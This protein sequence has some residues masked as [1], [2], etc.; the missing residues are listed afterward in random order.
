[1]LA[2]V[3]NDIRVGVCGDPQSA[4]NDEITLGYVLLDVPSLSYATGTTQLVENP[5]DIPPVDI[6]TSAGDPLFS[7]CA[8]TRWATFALIGPDRKCLLLENA[9]L[10]FMAASSDSLRHLS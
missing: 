5:H 3:C 2:I 8:L 6:C 1:M 4:L 7:H 10:V 9:S